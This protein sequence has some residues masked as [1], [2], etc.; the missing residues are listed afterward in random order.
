MIYYEPKK[1]DNHFYVLVRN[2][3]PNA[4]YFKEGF[5]IVQWMWS[6]VKAKFF[7]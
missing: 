6:K 2:P 3:K 5:E 7:S 4:N 1:V